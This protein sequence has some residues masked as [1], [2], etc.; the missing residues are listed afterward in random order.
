MMGRPVPLCP[1]VPRYTARCS[2][3][4][5][6]E[7]HPAAGLRPTF[8]DEIGAAMKRRRFDAAPTQRQHRCG[9]STPAMASAGTR[10][11]A[12]A[13]PS[14]SPESL[15]SMLSTAVNVSDQTPDRSDGHVS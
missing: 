5:L 3:E 1:E 12:I 11:S 4:S 7:C 13:N 6:V 2:P 14:M 10:G 8:R 9:A 15:V